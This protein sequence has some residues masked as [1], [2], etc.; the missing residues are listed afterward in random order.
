MA[1]LNR[2]LVGFDWLFNPRFDASNRSNYP[3]HNIIRHDENYYEIEIAVAGFAPS[4][5]SVQ[6]NQNLLTICGVK[7]NTEAVESTGTYIHRGLA[8]RDFTQEFTLAEHMEV[9]TVE[10][11]NGVL[12]IKIFRV[13]P[14]ALKPRMI[15]IQVR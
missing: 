1:D 8:T 14:E 3:P 4:E 11:V 9:Q 10:C 2:A 13:I 6:I 15:D 7:N 12:H 5:L